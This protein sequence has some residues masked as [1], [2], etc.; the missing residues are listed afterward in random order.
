MKG[1]GLSLS[2]CQSTVA[3]SGGWIEVESDP[4]KGTT[5]RVWFP[6]AAAMLS[7][8]NLSQNM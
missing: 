5:F 3:E 4:Q 7:E 6:A 1:I 8:K 2:V